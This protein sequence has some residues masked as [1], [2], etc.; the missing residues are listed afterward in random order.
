MTFF[1]CVSVSKILGKAYQ[2]DEEFL[3]L[4]EESP[5]LRLMRGRLGSF[6]A[7]FFFKT[8]KKWGV[9]EASEEE[10]SATLAEHI[11]H[12]RDCLLYTSPSPRDATLSRMPS[13]A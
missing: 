3:H 4:F 5:A 9:I 7:G 10:L 6:V 8:F 13:S 11:E 2:M 1:E 12:F